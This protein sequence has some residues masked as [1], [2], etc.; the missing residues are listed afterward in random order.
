MN[1]YMTVSAIQSLCLFCKLYHCIPEREAHFVQEMTFHHIFNTIFE[2]I[3]K[4][5]NFIVYLFTS[6]WKIVKKK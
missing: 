5:I 2:F 1:N 6:V 3:L 4:T